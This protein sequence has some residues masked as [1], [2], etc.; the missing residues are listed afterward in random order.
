MPRIPVQRGLSSAVVNNIPDKWDPT[1]FRYFIVN[2]LTNADAR[3]AV[4]SPDVLVSGNIETPATI[5]T[6]GGVP[7]VFMDDGGGWSD[8]LIVPGPAGTSTLILAGYK[9][10]GQTSVTNTL[11]NDPN[12]FVNI[13]SIGSYVIEIFFPV[14]GTVGQGGFQFDLGNT[15]AGIGTL[16]YNVEGYATGAT[17]ITSALHVL[18]VSSS[19]ANPSW[20]LVK[21]FIQITAQGTFGVRWS[22]LTTAPSDPT[23]LQ[24]GAF[25]TATRIG[26]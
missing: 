4:S 17:T 15:T 12:L 5:A 11:A 16:V 1:W 14:S 18:R 6:L 10:S 13:G 20:I 23:T 7:P 9:T 8:D 25:L 21:G 3:N 2:F 22:Q 24:A 26:A 19:S